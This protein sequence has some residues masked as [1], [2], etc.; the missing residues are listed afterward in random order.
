MLY[1]TLPT[2]E[3]LLASEVANAQF[4]EAGAQRDMGPVGEVDELVIKMKDPIRKWESIT[5][6][7]ARECATVFEAAGMLVYWRFKPR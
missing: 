5:G 1:L 2:G 6:Q 4:W 3:T 7:H